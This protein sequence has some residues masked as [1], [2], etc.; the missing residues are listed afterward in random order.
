MATRD[1]YYENLPGTRIYFKDIDL[2]ETNDV[3]TRTRSAIVFGLA[4]DGPVNT[5]IRL[6]SLDAL[7]KNYGGIAKTDYT[8]LKEKSLVRLAKEIYDSG[9]NDIR[10]VRVNGTISTIN[11]PDSSDTNRITLST[12]NAGA[13]YNN[14]SIEISSGE[15]KFYDDIGH[16][17]TLDYSGILDYGGLVDEINNNVSKTGIIATV[18]NH[19][20]EYLAIDLK[21]MVKTNFTGGLDQL[22]PTD[23]EYSNMLISGYEVSESVEARYAVAA[24]AFL[25][26]SGTNQESADPVHFL[27]NLSTFCKKS[28]QLGKP[29]IGFIEFEPL[30]PVSPASIES[31]TAILE[32]LTLTTYQMNDYVPG[33]YSLSYPISVNTSD[34]YYAFTNDDGERVI[35]DMYVAGPLAGP[36]LATTGTSLGYHTT[37][38]IGMIIG[39]KASKE[40]WS[41]VTRKIVYNAL[42]ST[43]AY[44]QD[45]LNRITGNNLMSFDQNQGGAKLIT[46]GT[47]LES[48]YWSRLGIVDL[49]HTLAA[50]IANVVENFEGEIANSRN[51][52]MMAESINPI[53]KTFVNYGALANVNGRIYTQEKGYIDHTVYIYIEA[54]APQEVRK[55]K[56]TFQPLKP[57]SVS[58]SIKT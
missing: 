54:E 37:T 52:G 23:E 42:D 12:L 32:N 6:R 55:I 3:E 48:G 29:R 27:Q 4:K 24:G 15:L 1:D 2:G 46:D 13:K 57:E 36:T 25:R 35:N 14:F 38:G 18:V 33:G 45:Q 30:R 11:L 19:G 22:T 41:N 31:R 39:I 44:S 26:V 7:G 16:T 9:C 40:A 21:D 51:I 49:Y 56:M 43:Y 47:M 58:A 50:N 34:T 20:D 28:T 53:I 17:L 5:P 10:V 8:K